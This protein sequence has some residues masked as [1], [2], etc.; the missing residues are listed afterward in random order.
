[1]PVHDFD[2]IIDR[3]GGDSAKWNA[4]PDDVLPMWVADADFT[5]PAPL[6]AALEARARHGVFGYSDWRDA[7][8]KTA[9]AHWMRSRFGWQASPDWVAFSPSVVV[10]LALS[11]ITYTEP[12]DACLFLTP[13]YP[14]FFNIPK[15]H[16]REALASP[17]LLENGRYVPDFDDLEAKMA[18]PRT[19]LFILCNPH[20]PTGRVF[21]REE[22]ARLG[23]L[24]LK[25]NLLIISDEIHCDYVFPGNEHLPLP[26]LSEEL[27]QR[28]LVTVN[29]S[30][31]FNVADLHASAVICANPHLLA[32][33]AGAVERMALHSSAMGMIA[34]K[35]AYLDCAWYADQAAVYIKAN[36]DLAV[37]FINENV[38]G[39]RS[40][41]PEATFLL[42]LD[43][44]EMGLTQKELERFFLKKAKLA[45]NSGTDFGPEGE[46][47]MR[48]NLAC[49]RSRLTEA[50]E[51]LEK[52]AR[53]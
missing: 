11:L 7:S 49:P 47:F 16:G 48:L 44:R 5:A 26:S 18:R 21:S 31:T 14:P 53:E 50:L 28:T 52:A 9:V 46:G 38:P 37:P 42:W 13:S 34:L 39:I 4:Y 15:A 17:L 24:C 6:V 3:R 1:M 20:N 41:A 23:E 32:R 40:Y 8:Y 33:F 29:P 19:R 25:H 22:L 2:R 43:C 51:R 35:T 36:I 10:S 45:L 27:A 30:K 12:G